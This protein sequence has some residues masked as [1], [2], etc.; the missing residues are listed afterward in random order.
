M[1]LWPLKLGSKPDRQINDILARAEYTVYERVSRDSELK[2]VLNEKRIPERPLIQLPKS[3]RVRIVPD[4]IHER[5]KHPD[6]R[7]ARRAAW[8]AD[9][10]RIVS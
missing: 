10:A 8:I 7:I 3:Y 9:L 2:A 5:Q 6:L 4:D 1:E